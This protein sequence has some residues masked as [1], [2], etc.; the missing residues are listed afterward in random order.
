MNNLTTKVFVGDHPPATMEMEARKTFLYNHLVDAVVVI[1]FNQ[2]CRSKNYIFYKISTGEYLVQKIYQ[3]VLAAQQSMLV[4]RW[5]KHY[6]MMMVNTW[7]YVVV[8]TTTER[9][10]PVVM[11]AV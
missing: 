9:I 3:Q 10:F 2:W 4:H 5:Y 1:L 6:N 11:Y 7:L 8:I